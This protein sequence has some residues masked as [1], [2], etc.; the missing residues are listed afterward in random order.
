MTNQIISNNSKI[1][2]L[3]STDDLNYE[4]IIKIFDMAESFFKIGQ[5]DIKKIPLLRGKTICNLF[6]ENSTRTRTTFEIAAKRLSADVINLDIPTSSQSKGESIFDMVDNLIAMGTDI[7]VVRHPEAGVPNKIANHVASNI[8][9][10]NGGDGSNAHPTQGLL[11]AFTI[12]KFKKNFSNLKIAIVGD[13]QHSRVAKSEINVLS[14]LGAKEIRVIGPKSLMPDNIDQL[15]VKVF[16]TME[17]GLKDVD[18]V[19]MLRIQKERM[20]NDT[21][22]SESEYF[23]SFGLNQK[24]LKIAK[25]NA[26]VLHPGPINR[27][28]EIESEVADGKQS[29]ILNQVKYGIAIRMA[30]M[31]MMVGKK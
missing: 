3:I 5:R 21:I 9:I 28:V 17:E 30:V 15:K 7:F 31:A 11:D 29:V 12:R 18:V 2:H 14:T 10:I 23:K 19:T 1:N 8:H 20:S 4:L 13:I 6:F 22:P 26:L 25:D 24:R 27:G 16:H